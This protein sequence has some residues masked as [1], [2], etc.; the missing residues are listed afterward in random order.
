MREVD[1][2]SDNYGKPMAVT[3]CS[4]S[5]VARPGCMVGRGQTSELLCYG[6][7]IIVNANTSP[8]SGVPA[9]SSLL[10][11]ERASPDAKPVDK[12]GIARALWKNG[13]LPSARALFRHT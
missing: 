2:L 5:N 13:L 12:S 6:G 3:S 8:K 1:K 10:G 4:N 11:A 7:S 9:G